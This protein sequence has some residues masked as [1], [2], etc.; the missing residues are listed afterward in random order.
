MT[1]SFSI[2]RSLLIY[3]ICVP[4]AILIGYLLTEPVDYM[5]LG[6]LGTLLFLLTFPLLLRWHHVWL[7]ASWNMVMMF[8]FL[9][10]SPPAWLLMTFISLLISAGQYIVNRRTPFFHVGSV[11]KPLLMLAAV[12]LIT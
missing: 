10:G 6:I 11:T 7:I 8:L 3:G 4:L 12:V 9:P 1:N 5:T 2:L